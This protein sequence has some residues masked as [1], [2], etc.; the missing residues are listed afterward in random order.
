MEDFFD[1]DILIF[2]SFF[3]K[4]FFLLG[5]F[6]IFNFLEMLFV[7]VFSCCIDFWLFKFDLVFEYICIRVVR[8]ELV[9]FFGLGVIVDSIEL[10][11]VVKD[12]LDILYVVCIVFVW[13]FFFWG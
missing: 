6:V 1:V 3:G 8:D 5:V 10:V 7:I 4:I 2:V 11:G 12:L 13:E 9:V